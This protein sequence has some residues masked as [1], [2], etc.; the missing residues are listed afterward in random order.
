MHHILKLELNIRFESKWHTGSGEGDLLLD[1]LIRRDA[2]NWPYIP[3]S[4]LKGVI[5]E[6]CE[7]LSRTLD[8]PDPVDPHQTDLSLPGAFVPLSK[9]PSPVDAVFGNKY[10]EGGL[11][12]RD[13]RLTSEPAY[14]SFPQSRICM[15]RKLGTA[16]DKHLFS[17][18]YAVPMEFKT[19]VDGYHRDLIFLEQEDPPYAYCLLIAGIMKVEHLGGD[20]STGS[21]RVHIT[22]DSVDYNGRSIPMETVFEYLDSGL[23]RDTKEI[24]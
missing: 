23:Y 15:Y 11:F 21:G 10:E 14:T 7:K 5:R 2:R 12:F 20:K 18:E 9:V 24:S 13:A 8:F 22:I 16:K 4:T 6:S 1:R 3:G 17:S 19:F